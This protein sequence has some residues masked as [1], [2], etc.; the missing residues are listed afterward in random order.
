MTS[1]SHWRMPMPTSL[2]KE[3]LANPTSFFLWLG[4]SLFFHELLF[5]NSANQAFYFWLCATKRTEHA[6]QGLN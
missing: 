5:E 1:V 6:E 4:Y 2:P 3:K